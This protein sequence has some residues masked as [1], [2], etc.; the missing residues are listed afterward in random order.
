MFSG[1]GN[2]FVTRPRQAESSDAWLGIRRH[3]PDQEGRKKKDGDDKKQ[4]LFDTDDNTAVSVQ[5]LQLFL[6]NFLKSL[7][8]QT[9]GSPVPAQNAPLAAPPQLPPADHAASMAASAY[10]HVAAKTMRPE[11]PSVPAMP[12]ET[13]PGLESEDV[14]KIH[15]LLSELKPL[16]ARGVEYLAIERSDSFLNSLVTAVN[17]AKIL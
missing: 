14:R 2:I 17:K 11:M 4:E 3:E 10:Q 7:A 6:E 16:A 13:P 9:A 15:Y 5:A 12:V 1:F 8:P